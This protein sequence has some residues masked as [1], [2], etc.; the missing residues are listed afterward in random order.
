MKT[1][2]EAVWGWVEDDQ[3]ALH[4][5]GFDPARTQIITVGGR[6]AGVLIV[7]DS[8]GFVYLGRIEIHPDYQG[9]GIGSGVIRGLLRDRPVELDVLAVN[10]R[11]HALYRRLGFHEVRHDDVRTRMRWSPRT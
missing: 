4:E 5:R 3:R 6:D 11:A 7:E 8:P 10:R 2:V 9:R 1:Y